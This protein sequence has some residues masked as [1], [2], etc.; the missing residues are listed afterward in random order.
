M[1]QEEKKPKNSK[2]SRFGRK[3][4]SRAAPAFDSPV[5]SEPSPL[6]RCPLSPPPSPRPLKSANRRAVPHLSPLDFEAFAGAKSPPPEEHPQYFSPAQVL[7]PSPEAPQLKKANNLAP[8]EPL[9]SP[10]LLLPPTAVDFHAL[11]PPAMR[12]SPKSP[13]TPSPQKPSLPQ[14]KRSLAPL[15]NKV[16]F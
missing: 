4:W 13:Q 2:L 12:F 16:R 10:T 11:P 8:E 7:V 14:K 9:V 3:G 5:P 15:V 1:E 6:A